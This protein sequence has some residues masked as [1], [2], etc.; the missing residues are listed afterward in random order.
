ML[1]QGTP[2]RRVTSVFA[3]SI[4]MFVMALSCVPSSACAPSSDFSQ[5]G[6]LYFLVSDTSPNASDGQPATVRRIEVNSVFAALGQK[7]RSRICSAASCLQFIACSC[8][9]ENRFLDGFSVSEEPVRHDL[10]SGITIKT[11]HKLE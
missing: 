10:S 5:N 1:R 2:F 11:K 8:E 9:Q 6:S 3:A 4:M 7:T